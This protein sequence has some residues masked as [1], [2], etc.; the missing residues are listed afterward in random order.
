[1]EDSKQEIA[2]TR[3][4]I[5]ELL[6]ERHSDATDGETLKEIEESR[7]NQDPGENNSSST[8]SPDGAVDESDAVAVARPR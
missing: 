4:S 2:E 3:E 5:D 6:R 7:A 8:I 1:M